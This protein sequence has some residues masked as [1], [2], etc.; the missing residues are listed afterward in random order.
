MNRE[1]LYG[2]VE[3]GGTKFVCC[4]ASGPGSLLEEA[5]FATTTPNETLKKTVQFFE[6][7]VKNGKIRSIGVGCFGPLDLNPASPT[8]GSITAT[9]KPGWSH[10]DVLGTLQRALKVHITIDSDVNAAGVGES[11]WG[12]SRGY[13]PSLYLTIGT[14]IG[15][16]YIKDGKSLIGL[17]N[18]EMGHVLIP[19]DLE[20]D[21]FEGVCPFHGD[22]FEGLANGP[23][24]EKRLGMQGAIVPE[25]DPYWD[26]E[27]GYIASALMNYI[28]TLSPKKIILGGG[29][30]QREFLFPKVRNRVC[31]LLNGYVT[32]KAVLEH[33][34]EYIVPPGLGN[35]SGSMGAI[36]LAMQ[37]EETISDPLL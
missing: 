37:Y 31:D 4:I 8:Y 9:P 7:F 3:A 17:L 15:G 14:G 1:K 28:L 18:L 20:R 34:D 33:I 24:I 25:N 2:G 32:S 6:P 27:A 16:G 11:I 12:S 26:V 22:C 21:P 19:H 29:V 23:A 30:M 13:D 35:Q 10:A 5:R 36:A